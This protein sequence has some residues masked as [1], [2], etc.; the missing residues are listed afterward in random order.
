M[1]FADMQEQAQQRT[2]E[3]ERKLQEKAMAFQVKI[4]QDMARLEADMAT[5]LQGQ[6]S[7]FQ[8]LLMQ[9]NHTIQAELLKKLFEKKTHN[10]CNILCAYVS[11]LL[12]FV[13]LYH[14]YYGKHHLISRM[15]KSCTL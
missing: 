4:D 2:I 13:L 15:Y 9:Q 11:L 10:I 5:R 8:M 3:H 7:Q 6:N 12:Y 1:A 14:Y